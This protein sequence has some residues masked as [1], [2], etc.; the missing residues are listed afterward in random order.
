MV[1][2]EGHDLRRSRKVSSD[3]LDIPEGGGAHLAQALRQDQVR[4]SGTKSLGVD[5][6]KRARRFEPLP[7]HSARLAA[8]L[9][10]IL[11][12]GSAH[13]RFRLDRGRMVAF[14]RDA[15]HI[16]AEPEGVA[17]LRGRGEEGNDPHAPRPSDTP[18]PLKALFKRTRR[19]CPGWMTEDSANAHS[20]SHLKAV[21][22]NLQKGKEVGV[23]PTVLCRCSNRFELAVTI[24]CSMT[25]FPPF[26]PSI[27]WVTRATAA[28]TEMS[29]R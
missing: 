27:A 1:G 8:R 16:L 24:P 26:T 14:R 20:L 15:D 18:R 2:V 12:Q 3:I 7:Y 22:S 19:R 5:L 13:D 21:N 6:V 29:G 9:A 25:D 28:S 23:Y 11:E 10:P 17:D 4:I